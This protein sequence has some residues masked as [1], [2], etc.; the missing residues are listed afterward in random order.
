V[1]GEA[2]LRKLDR[3]VRMVLGFF[4]QQESINANDVANIL[5][6]SPRQVRDLLTEWVNASWLV[7]NDTSRKS[8]AYSLSTDYRRNDGALN[9]RGPKIRAYPPKGEPSGVFIPGVQNMTTPYPIT[10]SKPG[11]GHPL[12]APGSFH[13]AALYRFKGVKPKP[14]LPAR[15]LRL[16]EQGAAFS[17]PKEQPTNILFRYMYRDAS[18]Y[19]QHGDAI[20]TNQTLLLP[21]DIEKQI[22][23]CL[24]DGEFFIARQVNIEERFFDDLHEDDHPWHTFERIEVTTLA[25]FDPDNWFQKQHR[26]DI[27]EFLADVE[28]AHRAGWDEMNVRPDLH[29][30]LEKQKQGTSHAPC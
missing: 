29:A 11:K 20:F 23:A 25:P 26:R 21:A 3:R 27:T 6:L 28:K 16:T 22:R 17:H 18:N 14:K 30:M 9:L 13:R 2:L 12:I 19:K 8:R 5:G 1:S 10:N 4:T 24:K 15:R 7:V